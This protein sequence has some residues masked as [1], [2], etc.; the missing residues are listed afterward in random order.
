MWDLVWKLKLNINLSTLTA[1]SQDPTYDHAY[2]FLPDLYEVTYSEN[3]TS[4][5]QMRFKDLLSKEFF[6]VAFAFYPDGALIV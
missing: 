5:L 4:R 3:K 2:N 6:K 1:T